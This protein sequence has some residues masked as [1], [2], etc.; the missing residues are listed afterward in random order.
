MFLSMEQQSWDELGLRHTRRTFPFGLT[1]C[2]E[3]REELRVIN[4]QRGRRQKQTE[5]PVGKAEYA[6]VRYQRAWKMVPWL[7]EPLDNLEGQPRYDYIQAFRVWTIRAG[8]R[9]I[10]DT[11]AEHLTEEEL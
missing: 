9:Y 11:V 1:K 8:N 2:P 5:C 7:L 3:C 6:Q 10:M 4:R